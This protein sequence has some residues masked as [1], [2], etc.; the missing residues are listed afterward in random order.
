MIKVHDISAYQPSSTDVFFFD[1]N[2]WMFLFCPIVGYGRPKQKLYAAFFDKIN[3]AKSCI[4]INSLVLSEFCNAWLRI[5]YNNW[6]KKTENTVNNDYKKDFVGSNTYNDSIEEIKLT[7]QSILKNVERATDDFNAINLDHIFTEL[8]N[9]DFNDSY[10]LELASR[11]KWK[12]VTDDAD[13]FKNN[14]LNVEIITA[15][16]K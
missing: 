9:C 7:L 13:L 2:V 4:W 1:N 5:V 16:I 12:I 10:Y 6:K 11:K 14:K 8:E 15:N 3:T